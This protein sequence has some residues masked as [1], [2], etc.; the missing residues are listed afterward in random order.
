MAPACSRPWNIWET[1]RFS[2]EDI[3]WL[4]RSGCFKPALIHRLA[5]FR[6][7]GHVHAM[8]EGTPFFA[9][10][11][12]L[13]VTA[14]LPEAQLVETT[15]IKILYFRSPL[16][17]RPRAWC[18]PRRTSCWLISVYAVPT[19]WRRACWLRGRA[20]SLASTER[21][22]MAGKLWD[23]PLYGTMAYFFI[24]TYD[25]EAQAFEDF[26]RSRPDRLVILLD[27]YDTEAAA[28]KVVA[29]APRLQASGIR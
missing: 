16:R 8:P 26:A 12:L 21:R 17:R 3:A 29:M 15:L 24:E 28:R 10:E 9:D 14:P 22:M 27:T 2:S 4:A 18:S 19:V 25:D 6:F 7:S 23:I 5:A 1:L 11:P 13:R 20:I